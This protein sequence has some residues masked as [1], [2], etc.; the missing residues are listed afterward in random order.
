MYT[1]NKLKMGKRGVVGK[2]RAGDSMKF[3]KRS[4]FKR[5]SAYPKKSGPIRAKTAGAAR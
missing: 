2:G 1:S 4:A 3:V 5:A